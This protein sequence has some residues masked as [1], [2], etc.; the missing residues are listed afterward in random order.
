MPKPSISPE[1]ET[2]EREQNVPLYRVV[3][4]DDNDHTYDY[5]IEMLQK[6]FIFTLD[7]AYRHA[8][9]VDRCGRTV[10]ITCELPQAEFARDQIH[11]YGADWRLPRSKGSMSAVV[12]P[13]RVRRRPRYYREMK[14]FRCLLLVCPA[15][16][17]LA[18]T[19]P[20][21]PA[22][23]APPANPGSTCRSI[24]P[25]PAMPEVPPDTVVLTVG[26]IKLTAAQFDQ[27]I[28][29]LPA[30]Y[31]A[32]ARGPGRKQFADN[33]VRMLVLAQE[34]KRRKLD[35]TPTYQSQAMFE[36]ANVLAGLTYKEISKEN[37]VDDA[38]LQKY[39]DAHKAEFEE[40]H[41]RHIL[42]RMQGSPLAV[43][44]GQKDLTDAE[45]L[46]KAQDLRKQAGGRGGF[47]GA[48][49]AGIGRQRA[50]RPAA[51]TWAS[52]TTT[53]WCRRS[54]KRLSS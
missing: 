18:Q 34:G 54:T 43:K 37:K 22:E 4:L 12:E 13:A 39:Y 9:E 26:D 1:T 14:L 47:R 52:S 19:P 44:P 46:A 53:R 29:V 23:A 48:G 42:I 38:E 33:L 36:Q 20:P 17:L 27:I 31:Q 7:Q 6:I 15:A 40:V 8:E 30:Q 5:V 2:L 3:L 51:A 16:C 50:P 35:E 45:A 41:A 10:L 32:A 11:S 25:P 24:R 21:K 28:S 49:D